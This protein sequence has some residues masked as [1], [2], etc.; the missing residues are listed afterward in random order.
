M[1]FGVGGLARIDT[2][3]GKVEE[4]M[5]KGDMHADILGFSRGAAQARAFANKL[6]EKYPCIKIRWMGLFDTVAT[7]GLPNNINLGYKLGIP[8]GTGA[9]F[10]LTAGGERRRSL[11]ALTSINAGPGQPNANPAYRE[12][13]VPGAVH[14]DVGGG[15]SSN[16]GLANLS[17]VMMW[18]DG[19]AHNVPFG[20][21]PPT[22][23]DYVG[24][25]HDSRW[26]S[27]R[28]IEFI[29]GQQRVRKVYYHP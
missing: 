4:F 23:S 17:L 29:T 9:V 14:S 27:D 26:P 28:I 2:M 18:Q 24:T 1:A 10:H 5:Q 8:E 22:Y 13:Q 6:K 15:Y 12:T 21:L 16:R 25:P 20:T 19:R 7:E 3:L 11:F